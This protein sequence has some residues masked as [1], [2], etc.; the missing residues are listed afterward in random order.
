M[1]SV[2]SPPKAQ[3]LPAKAIPS[4][5]EINLFFAAC[6]N[7]PEKALWQTAYF[8]GMRCEEYLAL[9][10]SDIDFGRRL[11]KIERVAVA[12][13]RSRPTRETPKTAKSARSLPLPEVL[14]DTL[15]EYRKEYLRL[16]LSKGGHWSNL[17]NEKD[18]VF[19]TSN[20]N[21]ILNSN[22]NRSFKAVIRNAN[23]KDRLKLRRAKERAKRENIEFVEPAAVVK[24]REDL[25]PY[26]LRHAFATH[27]LET[28][29]T[30]KDV[31]DMLGH[32]SIRL[33]ADVYIHLA[34]ERKHE[35]IKA[36]ENALLKISA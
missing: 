31:S 19:C 21:T 22:L 10:W 24:I 32:S 17:D 30:L 14:I 9:R 34:E 35:N 4:I 25:T 26:S 12:L 1:E 36:L 5:A 11:I 28:G 3:N 33:T 15:N 20:G 16:K 23:G 13:R 7:L 6:R 27:L 29:A 8:T 18:L 2:N